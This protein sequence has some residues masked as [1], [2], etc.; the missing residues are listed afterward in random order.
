MGIRELHDHL[1][2][3]SL[4]AEIREAGIP[5]IPISNAAIFI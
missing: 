4:K 5:A 1:L 2:N 3:F